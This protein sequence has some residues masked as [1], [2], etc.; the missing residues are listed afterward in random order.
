MRTRARV[1][2]GILAAVLLVGVPVGLLLRAHRPW[3]RVTILPSLGDEGTFP[4]AVNEQGQVAGWAEFKDGSHHLFLWSRAAGMQDLGPIAVISDRPWEKST[5]GLNDRGQIASTMVDPHGDKRAFLR[6]PNGARE[7]L[8]T[9]GGRES[10]AWSVNN[11]GQ[12]VGWAQTASGARHAFVWDRRAGMRDLGTLGGTGSEARFINDAG[13]IFGFTDVPGWSDSWPCLWDL[14]PGSP[15]LRLPSTCFYD[16]NRHGASVGQVRLS[17]EISSMVIWQKSGDPQELF[18]IDSRLGT[19]LIDR[20]AQVNDVN[21]VV[22]TEIHSPVFRLLGKR[23][24]T[25]EYFVSCLWD[26]ARGRIPLNAHA[27]HRRGEQFYAIDLNNQ[28]CIVGLLHSPEHKPG[29]PVLLEPIPKRW[30]KRP[31]R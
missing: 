5:S 6:D 15:A 8:G 12:V 16:L 27:P 4:A 2:T 29:R 14:P 23:F 18:R 17:G 30:G 20:R 25:P 10:V 19:V 7:V 13:Q 24:H 11:V 9:L 26:P 21:Q 1:I 31:E 3:Y 22:F 28:S